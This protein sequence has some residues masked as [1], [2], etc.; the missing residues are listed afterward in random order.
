MTKYILHGGATSSPSIH[1]KNFF[2]E[3][4]KDLS[5]P[6]KVLVV[7]FA[8]TREKKKWE[9]LVENDKKKFSEANPDKKLEFTVASDNISTLIE[10]ITSSDVIYIRGGI[11]T[12]LYELF[13]KIKNLKELFQDKVVAGSSAGAYVL[14]KYF[15]SNSRDRIEE[16]TGVLPIKTLAH[17][18]DALSGK[19]EELKEHGEDLRVYTIPET[20]FVIIEQ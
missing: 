14:S 8:C 6:V 19:L 17:Y 2:A 18:S 11:E 16:G 5:E 9:E 20:E 7:Y 1:N 15:Y 12:F 13:L 10:Q 3:T 4:T